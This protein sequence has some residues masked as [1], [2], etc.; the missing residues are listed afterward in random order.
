MELMRTPDERFADLPDYPFEPNY[1]EI[2][3]ERGVVARQHFL[4]EG[5]RDGPIALLLHGEPTWS[6]LYRKMIPILS[7]AGMRV[8]A[9]DLIGFGKSDKP[10]DPAFYS[11]RRNVGLLRQFVERMDIRDATLFCQ[12]WGG[13]LGLRVVSER[14]DLFCAVVASN[15]AL[16]TGEGMSDAFM[17]WQEMA[18]HATDLPVGQIVQGASVRT[19][20]DAEVFAYDAPFPDARYKTAAHVFP[21]LVPTDP[22]NKAAHDNRDAWERLA[23]FDKPFLTVFGDSDPVTAG[24]WR[25]MHKM[26]PGTSG[27][28]H[29]ILPRTGHFSQEDAPRELAEAILS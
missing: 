28:S 20:D 25:P 5:P 13:L 1:I 26:I 6:Y 19:L 9:P 7:G 3:V 22:N 14:P 27:L 2:E 15:T 10:A 8:I 17:A 12:D 24:A 18:R 29:R 11:Y 16:P 4:D 21:L 23:A